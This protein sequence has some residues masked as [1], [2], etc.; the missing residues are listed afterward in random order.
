MEPRE[1]ESQGKVTGTR[2]LEAFPQSDLL[3][4]LTPLGSCVT[5]TLLALGSH[6]PDS[7][8]SSTSDYYFIRY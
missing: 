6:L 1:R 5:F 7:V 8:A 3:A 2:C 4:F